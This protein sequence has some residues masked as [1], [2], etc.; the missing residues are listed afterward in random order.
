MP[1]ALVAP[2]CG[3]PSSVSAPAEG[4]PRIVSSA[5]EIFPR[6][7]CDRPIKRARSGTWTH[8]SIAGS[9]ASQG[10]KGQPFFR[11]PPTR[12]SRLASVR[13]SSSAARCGVS[14]RRATSC[15]RRRRPPWHRL[16]QPGT[17]LQ[18]SLVNRQLRHRQ[19]QI[20]RVAAG[21]AA[22]AMPALPLHMRRQRSAP[23]RGRSMHRTRA[24][25]L[26]AVSCHRPEAYQRQ[27]LRQRHLLTQLR[28]I[29]SRH[30]PPPSPADQRRGTRTCHHLLLKK[31]THIERLLLSQH[32]VD[33]PAQLGRQDAQCLF[34]AVFLLVARLPDLDHRIV[35]HQ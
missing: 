28:E 15:R 3:L 1:T 11:L 4:R 33:R 24:T 20:Q 9:S 16:V 21:A 32:V 14:S 2:T 22:K 5:C 27:D 17:E 18:C 31:A 29:N 34:L 35:P 8:G 13:P 12:S 30:Q 10:P 25:P 19:V 26:R 23:R 7:A 6:N